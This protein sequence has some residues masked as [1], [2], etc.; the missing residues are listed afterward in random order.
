MTTTPLPDCGICNGTG[1]IS[2]EYRD[3][4][5]AECPRLAPVAGSQC[6]CTITLNMAAL[7]DLCDDILKSSC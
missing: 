7:A 6:Y 1:K 2:Q 4:M 3:A 5:A